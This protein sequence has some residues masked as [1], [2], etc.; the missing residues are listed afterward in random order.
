MEAAHFEYS[1]KK[2]GS[3]GKEG[4]GA[5]LKEKIG[6]K[7]FFKDKR[8]TS[9]FIGREERTSRNRSLGCKCM[10]SSENGALQVVQQVLKREQMKM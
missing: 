10:V 6:S 2:F 9:M 4:I 7:S 5:K 8:K 1:F 3:E